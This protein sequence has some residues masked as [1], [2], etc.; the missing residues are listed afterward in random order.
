MLVAWVLTVIYLLV[1]LYLIKV[2]W[3]NMTEGGGGYKECRDEVLTELEAEEKAGEGDGA[4]KML[5]VC[6]E[7]F[8]I[9]GSGSLSIIEL[10]EMLEWC[11]EPIE[12]RELLDLVDLS[13]LSGEEYSFTLREFKIACGLKPTCIPTNWRRKIELEHMSSEQLCDVLMRH[14]HSE[15]DDHNTGVAGDKQVKPTEEDADDT[16]LD[17]LTTVTQHIK[18]SIEQF[19]KRA[20]AITS[21]NERV[22]KA[23]EEEWERAKMSGELLDD[24]REF[25]PQL[26]IMSNKQKVTVVLVAANMSLDGE[27][28]QKKF[29][30]QLTAMGY[31]ERDIKKLWETSDRLKDSGLQRIKDD[32]LED[33]TY[34]SNPASLTPRTRQL[35]G[36][37]RPS[38]ASEVFLEHGPL[39][40]RP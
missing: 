6:F 18:T 8:D 35:A 17:Q 2:A 24:W 36:P 9:D 26:Q 19:E 22:R 20:K 40:S 23:L 14:A 16:A 21:T 31:S 32:I 25:L 29:W 4:E 7:Q 30:R 12:Y 5:E 27:L 39:A 15:N 3:Y 37:T 10:R 13:L 38:D 11:A 34:D 33:M 28:Q 1:M